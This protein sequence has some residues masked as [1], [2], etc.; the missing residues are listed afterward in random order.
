MDDVSKEAKTDKSKNK[1]LVLTRPKIH[2]MDDV[3]LR[4]MPKPEEVL[5]IMQIASSMREVIGP[6]K[7]WPD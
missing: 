4:G 7:S 2:P 6:Q 3:N 5:Y 1:K